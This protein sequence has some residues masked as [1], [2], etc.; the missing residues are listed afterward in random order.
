MSRWKKNLAVTLAVFTGV[1]AVFFGVF[2]LSPRAYVPPVA[3]N[4]DQI[5]PYLTHTLGPEFFNQAQLLEPFDLDVQQHGLNDIVASGD[6]PQQ[7]GELTASTPMFVFEK[8]TIF[9]MSQISYYGLSSTLTI[10]ARPL[11][12]GQG[13]LN[14]NIQSVRLGLLPFTA[15]AAQIAQKA[16]ADASDELAEVPELEPMLRAIIT[17]TPFEPVFTLS[18]QRI[19]I[20]R[21]SLQ[22]GLLKLH[23]VPEN[24]AV[25]KY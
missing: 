17:N 5:S 3:E 4:P 13:R 9:L 24:K 21:F 1:A 14:V 11:Q 20:R 12:D 15:I 19:W 23:M 16:V 10:T 8:D 7:F 2:R 6:W 22:P 18:E 25:Y